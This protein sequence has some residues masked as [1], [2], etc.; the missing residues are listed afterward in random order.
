M[1][2]ERPRLVVALRTLGDLQAA[3]V[4]TEPQREVLGELE[5]ESVEG[6]PVAEVAVSPLEVEAERAWREEID[7]VTC[8]AARER[9]I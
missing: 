7:V 2:C 1:R 3:A 6:V 9:W 5:V 4:V 8:W